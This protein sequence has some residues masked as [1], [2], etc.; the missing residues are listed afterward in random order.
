MVTKGLCVKGLI[1][2][3]VLFECSRT[4]QRKP[5]ESHMS[6][7]WGAC[8]WRESWDASLFSFFF[9]SCLVNEA[10]LLHHVLLH[11]NMLPHYR[12]KA[13]WGQTT[14]DRDSRNIEPKLK[15]FSLEGDYLKCLLCK[16]HWLT[17]T[18]CSFFLVLWK[19][20]GGWNEHFFFLLDKSFT[21]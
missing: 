14:I 11:C 19:M 20:N 2:S 1:F 18:W 21:T 4:L 8:P 17:E 13:Q 12:P 5:M 3:L 15:S 10:A 9:A 6:L 7:R 16:E